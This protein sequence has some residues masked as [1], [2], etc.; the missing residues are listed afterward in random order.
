MSG[1]LNASSDSAPNGIA[2]H[3]IHGRNLPQRVCVR[4]AIKPRTG[5]KTKAPSIPTTKMTVAAVAAGMR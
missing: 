5:V 1:V 4:S 3:A 2:V